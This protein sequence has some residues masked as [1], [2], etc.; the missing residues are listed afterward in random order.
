[1]SSVKEHLDSAEESI[2]QAIIHC[3]NDK[4]DDHLEDLFKALTMVSGI[5]S[6]VFEIDLGNINL[7]LDE[8]NN[9]PI[10]FNTSDYIVTDGVDY[11]PGY[12]PGG[13]MDSLDNVIQFPNADESRED[14]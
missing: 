9:N 10:T 12:R 3:L 13:D 2:R 8:L 4:K 5:K 1:M 7:N 6:K 11:I 14:S